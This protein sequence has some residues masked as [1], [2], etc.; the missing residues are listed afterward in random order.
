V[1]G[2][3]NVRMADGLP[4]TLCRQLRLDASHDP[5]M[6]QFCAGVPSTQAKV[7]YFEKS[8]PLSKS[9]LTFCASALPATISSKQKLATIRDNFIIIS[10]FS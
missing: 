3:D 9:T 5:L 6:D 2:D 4:Q 1:V 8:V 10:P 7:L